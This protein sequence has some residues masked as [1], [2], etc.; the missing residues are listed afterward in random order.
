MSNIFHISYEKLGLWV[1]NDSK[2]MSTLLLD[3][4]TLWNQINETTSGQSVLNVGSLIDKLTGSI[5]ATQWINKA[6]SHVFAVHHCSIS[7][8]GALGAQRPSP[9][10][11]CWGCQPGSDTWLSLG[12]GHGWP[13]ESQTAGSPGGSQGQRSAVGLPCSSAS[14][15]RASGHQ[16]PRIAAGRCRRGTRRRIQWGQPPSVD[17]EGDKSGRGLWVWVQKCSCFCL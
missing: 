6:S 14:G 7:H 15:W 10:W 1:R 12:A 5:C 2:T 17:L 3:A 13:A 16:R 4:K 11:C 8:L 9:S